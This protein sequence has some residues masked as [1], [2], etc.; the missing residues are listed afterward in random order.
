MYTF[1]T[2]AANTDDTSYKHERHRPTTRDDTYISEMGC[3]DDRNVVNTGEEFLTVSQIKS[4][5]TGTAVC[6][7]AQRLWSNL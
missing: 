4:N 7:F 3:H 2:Q 6:R 5:F 1:M